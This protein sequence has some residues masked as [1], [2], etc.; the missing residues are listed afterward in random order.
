MGLFRRSRSP[1]PRRYERRAQRR[2]DRRDFKLDKK[3]ERRDSRSDRVQRRQDGRSDRAST[4]QDGRSD[5]TEIRGQNDDKSLLQVVDER[6]TATH[7]TADKL[8][9]GFA[10]GTAGVTATVAPQTD[11]FLLLGGGLLAAAAVLYLITK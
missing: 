1:K 8:F 5:R 10:S 6:L 11:Q 9:S 3:N 4:R 7:E 2:E